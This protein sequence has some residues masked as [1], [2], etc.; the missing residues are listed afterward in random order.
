MS[1][2]DIVTIRCYYEE[3]KMTRKD[4]LALYREGVESC[5]GCEK[6]RYMEILLDL[7]DGK[8]YCDDKVYD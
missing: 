6:M 5:D 8:N 1:D 7:M 3:R 4:A 2:N